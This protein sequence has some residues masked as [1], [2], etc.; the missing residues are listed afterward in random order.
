VARAI[1]ETGASGVV[2]TEKD[3]MRWLPLRPLPF[4][5]AAVPLTVEIGAGG[6][7]DTW[8]LARLR[9]VRA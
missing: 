2:T 9:E 6:E 4:A 8:L 7:F 3:A 5:M 1:A